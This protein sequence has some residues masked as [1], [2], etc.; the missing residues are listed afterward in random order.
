M[1]LFPWDLNYVSEGSFFL[2]SHCCLMIK[3]AGWA[4]RNGACW[5]EYNENKQTNEQTNKK[6]KEIKK[7]NLKR[8]HQ[9]LL[10]RET[11]SSWC[12]ISTSWPAVIVFLFDKVTF[13][14]ASLNPGIGWKRANWQFINAY[15]SINVF[16]ICSGH[17][18]QSNVA[19]LAPQVYNKNPFW[20]TVK[21]ILSFLS[22]I[23]PMADCTSIFINIRPLI[24][25]S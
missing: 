17:W 14:A 1:V 24:N 12:F 8:L 2:F 16:D 7:D 18:L 13:Q 25:L 19:L 11:L 15:L 9:L 3:Q 20:A 5:R 21:G 4:V 22:E 6:L 10:W 23:L